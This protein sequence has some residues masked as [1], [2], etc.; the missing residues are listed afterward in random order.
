VG[1][2]FRTTFDELL[3]LFY[4]DWW[5]LRAFYCGKLPDKAI[6]AT[7]KH[8]ELQLWDNGPAK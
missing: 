3:L 4:W 5:R 1:K 7:H 2:R 8:Q 6:K